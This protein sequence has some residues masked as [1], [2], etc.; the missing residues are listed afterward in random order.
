M[1]YLGKIIIY[2]IYKIKGEIMMK[3][4]IAL[5]LV[6]C[7]LA[8]LFM[9]CGKKNGEKPT[10]KPT[11]TEAPTNMWGETDLGVDVEGKWSGFDFDG[12]T[13][14]FLVLNDDKVSREWGTEDPGDD[15]LDQQISLRNELI[16][17]NL[18]LDIDIQLTGTCIPGQEWQLWYD[19]YPAL[20]KQDVD[21]KL[22]EFDV[23]ANYGVL[24]MS[25]T[26]MDYY[27]NLLDKD[28]LPYFDFS[29]LCWNQAMVNNGTINGQLYLAA[30]D[31]NLSLFN[32]S[33]I[34]W[35]NMDL[36]DKVKKVENGDSNDIQDLVLAG[37]WTFN[38]LYKWAAYYDNDGDDTVCEDVYGLEMQNGSQPNDAI[39]YAW[40]LELIQKN[41]DG[42]YKFNCVGNKKAE[43]ALLDFRRL[44]F[45]DG[46]MINSIK[47]GKSTCSCGNHFINGGV[48]F[49]ADTLYFNRDTSAALR[50]MEDKY[51]L[52]PWP[53]YEKEQEK[54]MTTSQD[55][56]TTVSVLDHSE[57]SVSTKG[58]AIS[59]YLQY[60]NEYSYDNVRGY[61]FHKIVKSKMLGTDDSDGHVSKSW[62][63]F[64]MIV[65]NIQFDFLYI[66][67]RALDCPIDSLW[68]WNAISNPNTVENMYYN[69]QDTFEGKL[70]LLNEFFGLIEAEE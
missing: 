7:T 70:Q 35:H 5:I 31:M 33:M 51:A 61:Y 14:T 1:T 26:L 21:N 29:L 57:C 20:I 55:F 30:G 64:V 60:S 63:I 12:D 44:Y 69:N 3:K 45:R 50:D 16:A 28:A 58:E 34:M 47:N 48:L 62:D 9:A 59:A 66:Y 2:K 56:L 19:V 22:H 52:V 17:S 37:G 23:V 32:S 4:V 53:K 24:G 39:I 8:V 67:N 25:T 38:E 41:S 54:Y 42:T 68:R 40:D 27:V 46:N 13:L 36:Y 49:K 15:E 11:E 18:N 43:D 10:A 65:D 6:L